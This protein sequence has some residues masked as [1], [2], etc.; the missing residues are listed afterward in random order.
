M[1]GGP[2]PARERGEGGIMI[3]TLLMFSLF[4]AWHEEQHR[5][6]G[7]VHEPKVI[8]DFTAEKEC[9]E[10]KDKLTKAMLDSGNYYACFP[11]PTWKK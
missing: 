1:D 6:H 8:A 10:M 2:D 7:I 4:V 5:F 3:Y 9:N 11:V